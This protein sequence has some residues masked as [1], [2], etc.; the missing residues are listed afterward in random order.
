MCLLPHATPLAF[1]AHQWNN[2]LSKEYEPKR[3]KKQQ[4]VNK[5]DWN[6]Q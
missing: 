3:E 4:T 6:Q 1:R 2:E 5:Q